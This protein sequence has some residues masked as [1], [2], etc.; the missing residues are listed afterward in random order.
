MHID[1]Y[2][3][4]N[5]FLHY[6]YENGSWQIPINEIRCI[7][8]YTNSDGPFADDYFIVFLTKDYTYTGSFYAN[9]CL[10][11]FK[12]LRLILQYELDLTL[13][14]STNWASNIL[15][16]NE[17]AGKPLYSGTYTKPKNTIGK[18]KEF[19]A[20]KEYSLDLPDYVNRILL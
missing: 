15:Y 6:E 13:A 5:D 20:G 10:K 18:I 14:C 19:I 7:G 12:D 11:V 2:Y 9:D 1:T 17:L 16:P 4:K 3:I 8:E